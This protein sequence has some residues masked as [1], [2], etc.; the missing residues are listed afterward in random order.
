MEHNDIFN[1]M[2]DFLLIHLILNHNLAESMITTNT[3]LIM[4]LEPIASASQSLTNI[5]VTPSVISYFSE[6]VKNK[7][8]DDNAQIHYEVLE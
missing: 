6:E 5:W 7:S 4:P 3:Q 2:R 8:N 1:T